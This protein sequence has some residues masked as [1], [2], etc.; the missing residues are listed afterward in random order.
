MKF[1]IVQFTRV[2][3][4]LDLVNVS[5]PY[6]YETIIRE[7]DKKTISK[8][9]N[10]K[11][12]GKAQ[13]IYFGEKSREKN[14]Y[15]LI[16]IYDKKADSSGDKNKSYLYPEHDKYENVTR[17]EVELREDLAK[18][19]TPDKLCDINYVFSVIVKKFYRYNYQFFGFLKF[20]DFLKKKKEEKSI[21]KERIEKIQKRKEHME[22]YGTSFRSDE[23]RL[24]WI[25]TF[26]TYG[27]RLL[28]DGIGRDMLL[29]YLV[30]SVPDTYTEK[31]RDEKV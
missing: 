10:D 16:R 14:T 23:E 31:Y 20:D 17:F 21:H 4:C 25:A 26:A 7:S 30:H 11:K 18:F 28:G 12:E 3:I 29:S 1:D 2:D 6:I 8:I 22:T 9:F 5:V 27:N 24:L 13:T 19:W 15:Q